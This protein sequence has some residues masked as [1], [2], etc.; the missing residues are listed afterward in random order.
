MSVNKGVAPDRGRAVRIITKQWDRNAPVCVVTR[1][2][3]DR[4]RCVHIHEKTLVAHHVD[5]VL[6][7]CTQARI[8]GRP[9][10]LD[11]FNTGFT[12][13]INTGSISDQQVDRI[14]QRRHGGIRFSGGGRTPQ[15]HRQRG[16]LGVVR[17]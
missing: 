4:F 8:G 7:V 13:C 16:R 9:E 3:N 12:G 11:A 14:D 10:R 15:R 2:R 5:K 6:R 1:T 17:W